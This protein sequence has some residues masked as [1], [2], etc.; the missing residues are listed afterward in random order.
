[1]AG[2]QTDVTDRRHAQDQ[3]IRD[4][5]YDTLTGLANRTLLMDRLE[6]SLGRAKRSQDETFAVLFLDLDRF[7]NV[8]DSLGH[9]AGDKALVAV[10][11]KLESCVRPGD[12]IARIGGD[13]FVILVENVSDLPTATIIALTARR[14][15]CRQASES[16]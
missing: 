1:M 7:K 12:T 4:A 8:N 6:Q 11:Q 5:L 10:A 14:F 15:S 13:E 9:L 3:L 2:S 16:S